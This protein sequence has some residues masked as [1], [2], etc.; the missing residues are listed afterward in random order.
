VKYILLIHHEEAIDEPERS[1]LLQESIAVARQLHAQ[2]KYLDAAPLHPVSATV[3]VKVRAGQAIVTDGPFAETREQ[4]GGYFLIE[5][6][7]IDEAVDIAR[8]IPGAR[9]GTVEVRPVRG[10]EG[11]PGSNAIYSD[12]D[13]GSLTQ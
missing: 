6:V 7:N 10:V 13:E 4:I 2:G 1:Q 8:R 11:L 3:S 12:T 5:A 9:I